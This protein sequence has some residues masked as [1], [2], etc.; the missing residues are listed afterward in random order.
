M[1]DRI[2]TSSAVVW[3]LMGAS[4]AQAADGQSGSTSVEAQDDGSVAAG[5]IIVTAQR[6]SESLQKASLSIAAVSGDTLA[7]RG[8]VD[9]QSLNG[10]V[11]GLKITYTGAQVQVFI[12]GVGDPAANP[13][14]QASVSLNLDGVYTARSTAF[15]PLFFD[16]ARVEVLRG[17]QGT[18]YGRNS[19]GGAI[20]IISN[21]PNFDGVSGSVSGEVGNYHLFRGQAIVN[22]PVSDTLAI[23]TAVQATTRD[24]YLSDGSNDDKSVAGRFRALWKPASGISLLINTDFA[25]VRGLGFN[26]VFRPALFGDAYTGPQDPRITPSAFPLLKVRYPSRNVI[27][28]RG[29]SAELNADLGSDITLTVIP[30]YRYNKTDYFAGTDYLFTDY[31]VSKQKSLEARLGGDN[32]PVKW[33]IGGYTFKEDLEIH[34]YTDQRNATTF[35]GLEQYQDWTSF[36]TQA[37]AVFGEATVSLM[38]TFRVIG[39]IRYTDEARDRSGAITSYTSTAGV[40][41]P[42]TI[43][44]LKQKFTDNAVTWKA[45]A[46]FDITP[47]NMAFATVS[48]GFKTGGFDATDADTYGPE[49]VTAYTVGLKNRFFGSK[50]TLNLEGF[51]WKYKDQQVSFLGSDSTGQTSF[52]TR[53]AGQST[54]YGLSADI[55]WRPTDNDTFSASGEY[56]HTNYD[57]FIYATLGGSPAGA[58]LA[59]GC[60]SNGPATLP[61]QIFENCSDRPLMRAPKWSGN[62]RYSHRFD[63]SSGG[64]VT[65]GATVKAQ[66]LQYLSINYSSPNFRQRGYALLDADLAYTAPNNRWSVQGF[67]SNITDKVVYTVA[68]NL[69]SIAPASGASRTSAA[70]IGQP[71]TFGARVKVNF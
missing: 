21:A 12:R 26:R 24:G 14:T 35:T 54:I 25:N 58:V 6:R 47:D 65:V 53:N 63:L 22:V 39:G 30:A 19:S 33:V 49:H 4:A 36:D 70:A 42:A 46:E 18:L 41:G 7:T 1:R 9:S 57:R 59:D 10:V 64:D 62:A 11:P 16:V 71:R 55:A 40:R 69:S 60:V 28:S 43:L 2:L 5:E 68:S 34:A 23:R 44:A 51:F 13:Y 27:D 52:V 8:V 17:P 15:G 67:V 32:G 29:F 3:A 31:D 20:N 61:G 48:K 45:G 38:D 50:L 66:S 56:L 37:S